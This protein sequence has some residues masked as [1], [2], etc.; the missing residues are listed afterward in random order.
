MRSQL[1]IISVMYVDHLQ[2]YLYFF[3]YNFRYLLNKKIKKFIYR[4][5]LLGLLI[6]TIFFL[7]TSLIGDYPNEISFTILNTYK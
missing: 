5:Q 6:L 3:F 1:A 2:K 4:F 7:I